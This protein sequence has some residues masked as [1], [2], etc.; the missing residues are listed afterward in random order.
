[1]QQKVVYGYKR[2]ACLLPCGLIVLQ[3]PN[4][5]SE[6]CL[7]SFWDQPIVLKQTESIHISWGASMKYISKQEVDFSSI[8]VRCRWYLPMGTSVNMLSWARACRGSSVYSSAWSCGR[9]SVSL[10]S[11]G[12]AAVCL[13]AAEACFSGFSE[14]TLFLNASSMDIC[15]TLQP[16]VCESSCRVRKQC[17]RFGQ[18][19]WLYFT[20]MEVV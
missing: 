11:C 20:H 9:S 5:L 3:S 7:C 14:L 15:E 12:S 2:S 1:M 18:D 16:T 19:E 6:T 10:F 17:S 13:S 8:I 4:A